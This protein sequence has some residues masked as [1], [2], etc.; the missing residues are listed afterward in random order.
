MKSSFITSALWT[1]STS[2]WIKM[3]GKWNCCSFHRDRLNLPILR[4]NNHSQRG[5]K[6]SVSK[7][8]F[9]AQFHKDFSKL[10]MWRGRPSVRV[11]TVIWSV[12]RLQGN[13]QQ[14]YNHLW[15]GQYIFES[16]WPT[17]LISPMNIK[18]A[19]ILLPP[20]NGV[21]YSSYITTIWQQWQSSFFNDM[22]N[23]VVNHP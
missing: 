3:S 19:G 9:I 2:L 23:L 20:Q 15:D 13:S 22:V 10:A 18:L 16:Q 1:A 12:W 4:R 6:N 7:L 11:W 21:F 14:H 8:L 5:R 17:G